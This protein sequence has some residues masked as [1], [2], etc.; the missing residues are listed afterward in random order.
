MEEEE[1]ELQT[2][3]TEGELE[4]DDGANEFYAMSELTKSSATNYPQQNKSKSDNGD[5]AFNP[6]E[7]FLIVLIVIK[8]V[9]NLRLLI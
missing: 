1:I 5:T 6:A 7:K 8:K 9:K 2:Q 4:R 3:F